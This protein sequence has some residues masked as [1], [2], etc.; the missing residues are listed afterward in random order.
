[1]NYWLIKSEPD[2]FSIED[3]A[4]KPKKTEHGDGMRNYQAHNMLRDQMKKADLV[5]FYHSSCAQP[6]I[7]GLARV[8]TEGYP[9][10]TAFETKN[11][12]YDPKSNPENPRCDMVDVQF[13][14]KF[15]RN[16]TLHELKEHKSLANMPLLQRGNRLSVMP[17]SK[18]HG[19][20]ILKL[21][22]TS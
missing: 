19:D 14:R 21:E 20:F 3:L 5:F 12:H 10:F 22:N 13:M 8:V 16:I 9:D 2:V 1:M 11:R 6:G 17:I 7:V 15:T 4:R 18:K